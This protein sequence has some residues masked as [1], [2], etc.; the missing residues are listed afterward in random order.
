VQSFDDLVAQIARVRAAERVDR[1][2]LT[3]YGAQ[4]SQKDVNRLSKQIVGNG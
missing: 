1:L 2:M 3:F 4:A